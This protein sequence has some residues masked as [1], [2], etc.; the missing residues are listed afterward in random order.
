MLLK[1]FRHP[2][3]MHRGVALRLGKVKSH[4]L[5]EKLKALN[6]LDSSL[7]CF[8]VI[9]HYESL[10]FCSQVFL[11]YNVDNGAIFGENLR[12]CL[13]QRLN[14]DAFLQVLDL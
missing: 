2:V 13:L 6:L 4:R 7:S 14:F 1:L 8:S 3:F 11:G 12:K 10:T 5:L 9:K